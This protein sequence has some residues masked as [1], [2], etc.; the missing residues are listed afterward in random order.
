MYDWQSA[1]ADIGL[2]A[3]EYQF[4]YGEY[5][6]KLQ[7]ILDKNGL[8]MVLIKAPPGDYVV[9][10]RGLAGIVGREAKLKE[11]IEDA[12]FYSTTLNCPRTHI[13]AGVP[14]RAEPDMGI[15]I[16]KKSLKCWI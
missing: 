16:L 15:S 12:I 8:E 10:D 4:P 14:G 5:V 7:T 9:G 11:S 13:I 3:V 2:K 6:A 1:A